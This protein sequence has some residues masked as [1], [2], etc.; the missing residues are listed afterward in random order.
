MAESSPSSAGAVTP[1]QEA[2]GPNGR[3]HRTRQR[4]L[5]AAAQ[6][7]GAQG[8]SKTTVE[9]IAQTA[10]V[11][12]GIVYHHFGS[13]NQVF[14]ALIERTLADWSQ[15]P[16]PGVE[17]ADGTS[18]LAEL[19]RGL[20][21][22]IEYARDNPMVRALFQRDATL[23]VALG[24]SAAVRASVQESHRAL[25]AVIHAAIEAGELPDT[26]DPEQATRTL[27]LMQMALID[28]V[29]DP[30][31]LQPDDSLIQHTLDVVLRGLGAELPR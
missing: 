23:L 21:A 28:H 7:F 27:H 14:D 22:S 8:L 3:S 12:K 16:G 10:G 19:R 11:S 15:L 5:D 26:L 25:T 13:K 17:K 31:W 29:L 9:E 30:Q 2:K 4:I 18:P 20:E 1:A 24:E 6:R